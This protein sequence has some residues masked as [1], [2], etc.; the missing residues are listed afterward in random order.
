[1]YRFDL[2]CAVRFLIRLVFFKGKLT[3][4]FCHL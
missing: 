2:A 1:V 4:L 3:F